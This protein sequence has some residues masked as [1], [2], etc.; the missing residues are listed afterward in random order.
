VRE[1][2]RVLAEPGTPYGRL[3]LA[4]L[5]G[6]AAA[7][8]TIGLLAGSG[9]VIGRAA[10]RPGLDALVGILAGVEV[11]AFLRGPIRYAERLVGHDATLR[12]LARWRIWLYDCLTP[13]VPAA[14]S[15]WRS[16]DLLTRAIDD[17]DT[18]A[19]LYLRTLLP[20]AIALGSA[21]IGLV[22]VGVILPA[23]VVALGL[24]LV[25]A[26]TVPPALSFRGA[27]GN[28]AATLGGTLA[29]QVVDAIHGAP[30]LVAFG[31][32][33]AMRARIEAISRRVDVLDD[34]RARA[35]LAAA[36]VT[37]LCLGAALA[38][39]VAVGV[40]AV[41]AHH[42][43]PVM[44][45]VLP[46]AALATFEP[47][48]GIAQAA[49]R[50][51]AVSAAARRLIDLEEVPIPVGDPAQPDHLPPGVPEL[52]FAGAAV[53]YAPE[54]PR[55]LDRV[56]LVVKP[57]ARVAVSGSSG[58]GKSSL[59]NALL[60]F[61]PLEEGSLTL[62]DIEATALDQAEVRSACA[63]VDQRAQLFAGTVRSNV[64]LGR[65]D[66]TDEEVEAALEAA[67]LSHWVGTLPSGL[68]TPVGDEGVAVSGGERRRLAVARALL[69]GGPV[70]VLDEPTGGL[71]APLA[72]QLLDD[73]LAAAGS[74]SV[75]LI[76]HRPSE[77]ARCDTVVTLEAGRVVP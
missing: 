1:I 6:L 66:A 52:S 50:A 27:G 57:G 75:L 3:A 47:M 24:P 38:A 48:T 59:V 29:A 37:Q 61:W 28:E 20:V 62:S 2:R 56:T 34:R 18:L 53:R 77:A 51:K 42:L 40:S 36:L 7:A 17:V 21:T 13:R 43:N 9:Y 41:H 68:E 55:A 65:P 25:V 60:R 23:A 49:A 30:D 33:V 67:H 11:L 73:V 31:A 35:D 72:D 26:C 71:D 12:A 64:I 4:G 74:R 14:L 46:L 70:L 10:F 54:L 19:D 16:G 22:V 39:V 45:A 8:A 69:A 58:A 44:V 32:D 5:L 63:L 76:T 15:G